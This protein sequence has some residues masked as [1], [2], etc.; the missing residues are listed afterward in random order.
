MSAKRKAQPDSAATGVDSGD[1][2][3]A[4]NRA[5][6]LLFASTLSPTTKEK[7][8]DLATYTCDPS[9]RL[10]DS[11]DDDDERGLA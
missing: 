6:A 5:H 8:D 11:S 1:A 3:A 2:P 9:I 4:M 7:F 10:E